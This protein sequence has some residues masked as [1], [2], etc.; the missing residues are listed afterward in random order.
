ME[1]TKQQ[2]DDELA[3][4]IREAT[5]ELECHIAE[6]LAKQRRDDVERL[7]RWR[8]LQSASWRV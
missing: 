5:E 2:K 1:K 7:R 3:A 6:L 8:A 4:R